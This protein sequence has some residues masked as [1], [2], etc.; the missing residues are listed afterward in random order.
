[1]SANNE[2]LLS[3]AMIVKDEEANIRRALEAIKDVADE[4]I[5]VDTGSMDRTPQIVKEYTD[6]LYFHEWQNDFSEARNYSLKFPTC[7]WVMRYD[8]DEEVS[9]S[10]IK[11]IREFLK[12]LPKD[13]NTV[14]LPIISYMDMDHTKTEVASIPI[15]F[16]KGT[17]EYQN[18][19]HN[20]A[21]YKPKVVHANFPIYHYGYIWTRNLRKKKH[22]R[23]ATLIREQL[24]SSNKPL[25]R[26]YYLIQLYKIEEIGRYSF[27]RNELA[28]KI[29]KEIKEIKKVNN[30]P[31]ITLEF[32]YLFG[33]ECIEND[34][35]KLGEELLR[36]AI[37]LS[38]KYPD[39]YF[40][41]MLLCEKEKKYDELLDWSNKFFQVLD[42]A[43]NEVETYCWTIMSL[44]RISTAYLL[45]AKAFLK[46]KDFNDFN[47]YISKAFSEKGNF[48][49][50]KSYVQILMKNLV[51][52][53]ESKEEMGKV[54]PGIQII[55]EASE[56]EGIQMYFDEVIQKLG[57]F[58]LKVEKSLL[59]KFKCKNEIS[60]YVIKKFETSED[61]LLNFVT[62]NDYLKFVN[63]TG[64]YGLLFLFH[65]LEETKSYVEILKE[66]GRLR[67]VESEE[68]RGVL[69][70]LIGDAYLKLE[71]YKEAI[72]YYKKAKDTYPEISRFIKPLLEDLSMKLSTE[73]DIAFDEMYTFYTSKNEFIFDIVEYLGEDAVE[74]LY[75]I[76]DTSFANY[77]SASLLIE[78][79]PQ[80]AETLLKKVENIDEFPFYYYRLAK[81][82]EKKD[83]KK[84]LD[85]H[86][87]AVEEN[88]KLA[89]IS[90]GIYSYSG[91]YPNTQI[92]FMK[93]NDEMIW[94]GNISEK[95]ST[96]GII[97]PIRSWKKSDTFMYASPY[98]SDEALRIY[99]KREKGAYKSVPLEI[100]KEVILRGLIDSGFKDVKVLGVDKEKYEGVFED[101]GISVKDNSNNLLIVG[102][103][104]KSYDVTD[105]LK[106][107][108]KVLAFVYVPDL[109]DRENV[110]WFIPKFR[111]LRT[112]S[113]L[114]SLFEKEGF[115][116]S[117]V[118]AIDGNLRC[119]QAYKE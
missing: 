92:S 106:K 15:I 76:S 81:I 27:R 59:E 51:D 116:V 9:E 44:K 16:R 17:V 100:K 95:F 98:P 72:E 86:I 82:Y 104:E 47:K 90:F 117:K 60:K 35:K 40:G 28:W 54:L 102:E 75:L 69:Y 30:L 108:K 38:P 57:E 6:K 24:K 41:M 91:L 79:D 93:N 111:V 103:F 19:V 70:V 48:A 96:L 63:E 77:A 110:V 107:A 46:K 64:I 4:I 8:A 115:K 25:D 83:I 50:N 37:K 1:M 99:E 52:L 68:V 94:V 89:D 71:K 18:V 84:A 33:V 118:E 42:T 112:T 22:E 53:V 45:A 114:I 26:I 23:T 65:V 5:V 31:T 56:N 21:I 55:V 14:Y 36:N 58:N 101:L 87:K 13:V 12:K 62:K 43:M 73:F 20:Q 10:F 61:Q 32:L 119:I 85:L 39:P 29:I 105:I 49:L 80:K 11:N 88:N 67:K 74:K 66:L 3:V 113:Q 7:E 34:M 2:K 78:K 109:K 97:H